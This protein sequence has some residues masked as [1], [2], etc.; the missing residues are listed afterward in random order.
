MGNCFTK[1]E[2]NLEDHFINDDSRILSED[3]DRQTNSTQ[4]MDKKKFIQSYV[5][6]TG[7]IENQFTDKIFKCFTHNTRLTKYELLIGLSKCTSSN[8]DEKIKFIFALYDSDQDGFISRTEFSQTIADFFEINSAQFNKKIDFSEDIQ[9]YVEKTF[10]EI[11]PLMKNIISYHEFKTY[12]KQN[13]IFACLG[14][15]FWDIR[16]IVKDK[17]I[18]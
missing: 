11:S 12:C 1:K 13:R 3:F 2:K 15:V 7:K 17:K 5:G 16:K 6:V 18:D 14:G 10:N 4:S 8:F 9:N